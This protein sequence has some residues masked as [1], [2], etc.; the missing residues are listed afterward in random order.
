MEQLP[1]RKLPQTARNLHHHK[2][3]AHFTIP[4][5]LTTSLC[6]MQTWNETTDTRS[7]VQTLPVTNYSSPMHTSQ[8]VMSNETKRCTYYTIKYTVYHHVHWKELQSMGVGNEFPESNVF[9]HCFIYQLL[10]NCNM[11]LYLYLYLEPEPNTH[12]Y[13]ID[14]INN[15][16]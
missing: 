16:L 15:S 11:Y 7:N 8:T 5:V 6:F 3:Y 9:F 12:T 2:L 4:V 13:N 14:H 10:S 1:M